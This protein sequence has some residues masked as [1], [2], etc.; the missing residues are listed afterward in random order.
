MDASTQT[1]D[2]PRNSRNQHR[3]GDIDMNANV[4]VKDNSERNPGTR[5]DGDDID[6]YAES[7]S[8]RAAMAE[9]KSS[10]SSALSASGVTNTA[11]AAVALE[12]QTD[13]KPST[14]DGVTGHTPPR[15]TP[16]AM[17]EAAT[18][19]LGSIQ[20]LEQTLRCRSKRQS[21]LRESRI[22]AVP[23]PQDAVQQTSVVMQQEDYILHVCRAL[24][25]YGAPTHR[26]E[27]YM[28][29]T[30]D[31]F[32]LKLQSFYMPGC[33]IITFNNMVWRSKDVQIIR[34]TESLNLSK[35]DDVHAVFKDVIHGRLSAEHATARIEEILAQADRFP[36][37]ARVVLYG[38]A[39]AAIGP[40]SYG[41]RPI[42]LPIIFMLGSL[43]GFMQLILATKSQLYAH[44]F[45][46]SIAVLTSFIAR[47]L[48]S[49]SLAPDFRFCFAAICQAPL[50][51]IVPGFA[52]TNS[53]LEL[54]SKNMVSGSVR[55]VYGIIFTLFLAFGITIGVTIYG[56]IDHGATSD[57]KCPTSLPFW[58]QII[59]VP[60][61]TLFYILIQQ[62]NWKKTPVMVAISL[63]G[64]VV[65]HFSEQAFSK[66]TQIA[67]SLGALTVGVLAN[68][69]SRLGLGLAV[70][71]MH[72]AIFLQVPGSLAAAGGLLSGLKSADSLTSGWKNGT[73]TT[74]QPEDANDTD[75]LLAGYAMI[76]IAIGITI[77]LS[78]SALLVYPFRK[79][80]KSGMFTY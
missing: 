68:V 12:A 53:A 54:Q 72:P 42:D 4:E 55:M 65:N 77:G 50:V 8:K 21:Q 76:R 67:Q 62:G 35:L 47:A 20:L 7:L 45:E 60:L 18:P 23:I 2:F 25:M 70:S 51:M 73:T 34:C 80:V 5:S 3:N 31:A 14:L 38:L 37:W 75:V 17:R 58:W 59:W 27:E 30:A 29:R 46:I 9:E 64:W 57:T 16:R 24:M 15:N 69:Y 52:I 19:D 13:E 63:A 41:A 36:L 61:F 48:G 49:I 40:V 11:A 32:G 39:S 78:V 79:K 66:N 33:M 43:L 1:I 56:A 71:I 26:L 22:V 10:S 28:R 6:S 44:V 74:G